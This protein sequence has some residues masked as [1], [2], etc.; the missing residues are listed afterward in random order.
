M[1]LL[2]ALKTSTRVRPLLIFL[3]CFAIAVVVTSFLEQR[4]IAISPVVSVE[5]TPDKEWIL[6]SNSCESLMNQAQALSQWRVHMDASPTLLPSCDCPTNHNS[7]ESN[8]TLNIQSL[9]TPEV[10]S[11]LGFC[12]SEDGPNCWNMALK[13]SGILPYLRY[14]TENEIAAWLNSPLCEPVPQASLPLPGDLVVIR[15]NYTDDFAESH[16]AIYITPDLIFTKN[17]NSRNS[18]YQFQPLQT[19]Y[20]TY[21]LR[22]FT[23]CAHV[24]GKPSLDTCPVFSNFYRC[25]TLKNYLQEHPVQLSQSTL[26]LQESLNTLDKTLSDFLFKNNSTTTTLSFTETLQSLKK[27]FERSALLIEQRIKMRNRSVEFSKVEMLLF[28]TQQEKFKAL[29]DQVNQMADR[30]PPQWYFTIAE[31]FME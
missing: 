24:D 26:D 20:R 19:L 17:G 23:D 1:R 5:Q 28:D 18:V 4:S 9:L 21:D 30:D 11:T 13:F 29:I 7:E 31:R 6:R 2:T 3:G 27:P 8:C 16:A 12:S 15:E 25:G 10:K 14:T 22:K